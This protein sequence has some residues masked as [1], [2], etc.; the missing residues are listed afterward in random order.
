MNT[1]VRSKAKIKNSDDAVIGQNVRKLRMLAG[2]SQ[3]KLGN[4]LGLT[5][6]QVQKY[7]KGTNRISG[8]RMVLIARILNCSLDD[9]FT[10]TGNE[11]LQP[12]VVA[13]D[14]IRLLG[15]N[16]RG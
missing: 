6:Q 4:A 1:V 7:E 13:V 3:E 2:M 9:L 16:S 14:P 10:D 15:T 5:F 8:G 11:L 12:G